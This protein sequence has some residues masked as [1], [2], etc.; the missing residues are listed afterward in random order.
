MD[1]V[2]F[3]VINRKIEPEPKLNQIATSKAINTSS[4]VWVV[5]LHSPERKEEERK[6][7]ERN[8]GGAEEEAMPILDLGLIFRIFPINLDLLPGKSQSLF[9]FGGLHTSHQ[10]SPPYRLS[11][12][13]YLI[14]SQRSRIQLT[15][16]RFLCEI[17]SFWRLLVEASID[18][19]IRRFIY[20]LT[21]FRF[22]PLYFWILK[23]FE[24][25]IVLVI[26]AGSMYHGSPL[27]LS[28][29]GPLTVQR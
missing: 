2:W 9:P 15:F 1:F 16:L 18:V 24:A 26:W 11:L 25:E 8:G 5:S 27:L 29:L 6:T 7:T 4:F 10:H 3:K 13:H 19:T 17:F 21:S 28:V 23:L 14:L 20:L 22:D 12:S